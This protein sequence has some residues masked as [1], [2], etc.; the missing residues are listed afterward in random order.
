MSGQEGLIKIFEYALNQEETGISFFQNSLQRLGV[1]SAVSAFERL[2]K[3]EEKHI[4]FLNR[5]IASIKAGKKI[6]LAD[7]DDVVLKPVDY[8]DDRARSEFV[9]QCVDGSMVPDVTVFNLAWLIEKDLS[10]FYAAMADKTEGEARLA[11]SM[12][13]DWEKSHEK[14]FRQFRDTLAETYARM[15]WGG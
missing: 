4:E 15:P 12:L 14:F 9:Q 1:G 2:I 3:E 11:L 6:G 10:E 8:F 7:V 5:L 13:A